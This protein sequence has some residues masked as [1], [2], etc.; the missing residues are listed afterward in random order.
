M[1]AFKHLDYTDWVQTKFNTPS[2]PYY[3]LLMLMYLVK[4][5]V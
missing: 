1:G 2:D 4:F 3:L 5:S